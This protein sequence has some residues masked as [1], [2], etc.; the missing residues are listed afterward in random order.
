MTVAHTPMPDEAER[1]FG[2]VERS[3]FKEASVDQVV[4]QQTAIP[5]E[6]A[7]VA[8]E[9]A[10][11]PMLLEFIES[12]FVNASFHEGPPDGDGSVIDNSENRLPGW[13]LVNSNTN[14]IVVTWDEATHTVVFTCS[15]NVVTA[16]D[17]YLE[18]FIPASNRG[19]LIVPRFFWEHQDADHSHIRAQQRVTLANWDRSSFGTE[20]SVESASS[21]LSY[22][23]ESCVLT[24]GDTKGWLRVRI[25]PD[26][27]QD[28]DAEY[29]FTISAAENAGKHLIHET[30]ITGD[31]GITPAADTSTFLKFNDAGSGTARYIAPHAGWVLSIWGATSATIDSGDTARGIVENMTRSI[32][33]I[34]QPIL[35]PDPD[36]LVWVRTLNGDQNADFRV[37]DEIRLGVNTP[38]GFGTGGAA[39]YLIGAHLIMA[40]D[41]RDAEYNE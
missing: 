11:P 14:E 3:P 17:V 1:L 25:G 19:A 5:L 39:D 24:E 15:A 21:L 26:F 38:P 33:V 32:E 9:V 4:N 2:M 13:D 10:F 35:F 29:V 41:W 20:R 6:P 23:T 31:T 18:Q 28:L 7:G 27:V 30:L 8:Q 37:G 34:S 36:R 40:F 22:V 16:D 12:G